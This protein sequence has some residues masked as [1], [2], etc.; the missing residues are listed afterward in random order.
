MA[1]F[2][3]LRARHGSHERNHDLVDVLYLMARLWA[4][5]ELF[6]D[7]GQTVSAI[8]DTRGKRLA[9]FADCLESRRVRIVRRSSQRAVAELALVPGDE[10]VEVIRFVDFVRRFEKD[11]EAQRWLVRVERALGRMEHTADRQR[12]LR[13]GIVVHAMIDTLDPEHEV[14]KD[15][16][17]YAGKLSYK[18][19]NELERRVFRVYLKFVAG[20]EKY[21]GPPRRRPQG[22][23]RRR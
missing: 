12:L 16:R 17:S 8:R 10:G 11:A 1:D 20:T 6:R 21:L 22:G 14:S 5:L 7:G 9:A 3:T 13:Y 4:S 18:S 15:R 23:G 2:K 19:W